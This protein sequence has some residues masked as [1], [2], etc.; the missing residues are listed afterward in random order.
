MIERQISKESSSIGN[1]DPRP[2][3]GGSR[4]APE[5]LLS[6]QA[7]ASHQHMSE[8]CQSPDANGHQR[9]LRRGITGELA[10]TTELAGDDAKALVTRR[11]MKAGAAGGE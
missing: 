5:S 1:Q 4:G 8:C 10:V 6:A 9:F 11:H 7:P 3:Q 2:D